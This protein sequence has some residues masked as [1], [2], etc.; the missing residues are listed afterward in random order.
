MKNR[1]NN[2]NSKTSEE[3]LPRMIR[4]EDEKLNFVTG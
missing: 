2:T 1:E 3:E 4:L